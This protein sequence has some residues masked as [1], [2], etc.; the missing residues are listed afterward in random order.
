MR[1]KN[2]KDPL[3]GGFSPTFYRNVDREDILQGLLKKYVYKKHA[4]DLARYYERYVDIFSIRPLS[5][6]DIFTNSLT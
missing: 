3:T 5:A 6:L 1:E 4:R 2:I